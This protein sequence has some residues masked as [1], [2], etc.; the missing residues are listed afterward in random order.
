[1]ILPILAE[2]RVASGI[3]QLWMAISNSLGVFNTCFNFVCSHIPFAEYELRIII[4]LD[5]CKRI[6]D[7]DIYSWHCAYNSLKSTFA[8]RSNTVHSSTNANAVLFFFS[9]FRQFPSDCQKDV[10]TFDITRQQRARAQKIYQFYT[11]LLCLAA[12]RFGTAIIHDGVQCVPLSSSND[13]AKWA[14]V[15][16]IK[17]QNRTLLFRCTLP[18]KYWIIVNWIIFAGV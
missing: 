18:F 14:V 9:L 12:L 5:L 4:I 8:L 7:I 10:Q 6:K 13:A 15:T 2:Q 11:W 1:M 3:F 17:I 16:K